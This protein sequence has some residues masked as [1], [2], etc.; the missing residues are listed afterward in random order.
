MSLVFSAGFKQGTDVRTR[1]ATVRLRQSQLCAALTVTP[2]NLEYGSGFDLR[3]DVT[4]SKSYYADKSTY[5]ALRPWIR[6][7][8]RYVFTQA[9]YLKSF[10]GIETAW[11]LSAPKVNPS[12]Y[13]RDYAIVS[14]NFPLGNVS[15]ISESP[16]SFI[17]GHLPQF[18]TNIFLGI[19]FSPTYFR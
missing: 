1:G 5:S 13:Y 3:N 16:S 14:G 10:I 12:D 18:E 19:R 9:R 17:K 15:T 8:L 4:S 11:A 6:A 7:D 2:S